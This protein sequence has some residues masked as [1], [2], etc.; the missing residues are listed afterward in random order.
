MEGLWKTRSAR[1]RGFGCLASPGQTWCFSLPLGAMRR[2]IQLSS[3]ALHFAPVIDSKSRYISSN[4]TLS[5][6][7]LRH[8]QV[9]TSFTFRGLPQTPSRTTDGVLGGARVWLPTDASTRRGSLAVRIVAATASAKR[10]VN[11]AAGVTPRWR[12]RLSKC[13]ILFSRA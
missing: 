13:E 7:D 8:G 1:L 2:Y 5:V 9:F 11:G 10:L 3:N 12:G 6:I 4:Y